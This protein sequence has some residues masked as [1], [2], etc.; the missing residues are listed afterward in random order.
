MHPYVHCSIIYNSQNTEAIQMPSKTWMDKQ[1]MTYLYN[2]ILLTHKK[3]WNSVIATT[4][5]DL[6]GYQA[7]WNKWNRKRQILYNF[8][9]IWNLKNKWM[10]KQTQKNRIIDKEN[11]QVVAKVEADG[12]RKERG[13]RY[14]MN[15]VRKTAGNYAVSLKGWH[16]ITRL[17]M[18][19]ILKGIEIP[20]HCVT[21]T[22]I[23][24]D[25]NCTSKTEKLTHSQKKRSLWLSEARGGWRG[26]WMKAVKRY[27]L[28]VRRQINTTDI[29]CNMIKPSQTQLLKW[30]FLICI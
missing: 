18:V 30:F 8:T 15:N 19:I 20:N 17:I 14:K 11:K 27:K 26:R 9:H 28:P 23:M 1:D 7:K 21:G 10:N 13:H 25:V 6:E 16:I 3:E 12:W 4:W 22:N 29:R 24:L 5:T 2:A